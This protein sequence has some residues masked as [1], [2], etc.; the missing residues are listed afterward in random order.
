MF[1]K[2]VQV[3][4]DTGLL[5]EN[6]DIKKTFSID[7]T[8]VDTLDRG[9]GKQRLEVVAKGGPPVA[10]EQSYIEFNLYSSNNKLIFV[11]TYSKL[12]DVFANIGGVAQV[13]G[14]VVVFCYSWYNGIRMEQKLINF[15][16]LNQKKERDEQQ[17][18]DK[19]GNEDTDWELKRLFTFGELCKIGLIQKKIGCCFKNEKMRKRM[20]FYEQANDTFEQRTDVINIMKSVADIDTMKEALLTPYQQRLIQYL[21]MKKADDDSNEKEMSIKEASDQLNQPIKKSTPIQ[22]QMD[23]YL[24]EH[25]PKNFL[26]GK[27]TEEDDTDESKV[28]LS[29][30][31]V[32]P[33]SPSEVQRPNSG[34]FDGDSLGTNQ[35]VNMESSTKQINIMLNPTGKKASSDKLKFGDKLA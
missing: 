7:F 16:V 29:K 32:N 8:I 25:L 6:I 14:F 28:H 22:E 10:V 18:K 11:R 35:N 20:E 5:M 4:T 13:I 31:R 2:E 9:Q 3:E 12:I 26:S 19:E 27:F 15:G 24:K 30:R 34:M 21:A 17:I 23:R 33:M 1:W